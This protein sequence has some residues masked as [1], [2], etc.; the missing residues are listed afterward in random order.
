M[1]SRVPVYFGSLIATI[2]LV[3]TPAPR[4]LVSAVLNPEA[5]DAVARS[6]G[7]VTKDLVLVL[8]ISLYFEWARTRGQAELLRGI[9][10]KLDAIRE[11]ARTASAPSTRKLVLDTATPE[12]LV[13][14]ALD[15]HMPHSNDKSS[16]VPLVLSPKPAHHDVSLTMRV[17]RGVENTLL[18]GVRFDFTAQRGPIMIAATTSPT[19]AAAL[20]A[21]CPQLFDAAALPRSTP[22]AE[23]ADAYGQQIEC[24]LERRRE[25]IRK[26]E[27]RRV[28]TNA[29]TR[30]ISPPVGIAPTDVAL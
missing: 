17:E 21:A 14:A 24:Y 11:D 3:N 13:E 30:Y 23:A 7:S 12:E 6:L 27:F 29:V 25:G 2:V 10:H 5:G 18:V 19:H 16:F 9:A 1:R 26:I 8:L 28:P 22:F 15:R 4:I 20:S